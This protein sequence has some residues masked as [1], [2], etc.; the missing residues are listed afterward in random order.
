MLLIAHSYTSNHLAVHHASTHHSGSNKLLLLGQT[1]GATPDFS[2]LLSPGSG[3]IPHCGTCSRAGPEV[4]GPF[5]DKKIDCTTQKK[6]G[7][8]KWEIVFLDNHHNPT[9]KQYMQA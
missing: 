4:C 8:Q 1:L 2:R 9:N 6:T 7:L 5:A 3:S